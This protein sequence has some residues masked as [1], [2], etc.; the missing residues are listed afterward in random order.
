MIVSRLAAWRSVAVLAIVCLLAAACTGGSPSK[1]TGGGSPVAAHPSP[2]P[3]IVFILT[4]DLSMNLLPY[5][6]HVQALARTGVTFNNYFVVDSLCCP[7]RSAI[8]TGQYPHNNGVFRNTGADGGYHAYNRLGNEPKTFAIP[9]RTAGYRTGFMGKYLNGY[10]PTDRRAPGW[11]TWDGIGNGYPE[12]NYTINENGKQVRYGDSPKD[13]LNNV[14]GA[15]ASQFIQ[16]AR[17]A[18]KPFALEVGT[19]TPHK[20][21]IPAPHDV[22]TFPTLQV[23]RGPAFD[24]LPNN[25]PRWLRG[26]PPLSA[27]DIRAND[28]VF[29]LRVEAVQSVDRMIGQLQ[30]VLAKTQELRNTYFVFSSDNGFHIGEYRL[31]PGKTTAFDTDIKVPLIVAGPGI[32]AGQTVN[33]I[34]TSIDLSSTFTQMVGTKPN[35]AV[36]GVSLLPL[37]RGAKAPANWQQAVL[38]E[39]HGPVLNE[40]DPDVQQSRAGNPPS[41]E[42]VR[43]ATF[44][45]VEYQTGDREYY[46]LVHDPNELNNLAGLLPAL[47]QQQLHKLLAGLEACHGAPACQ[48]AAASAG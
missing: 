14:L 48:A 23:P 33:S 32:P 25:A 42:A 9:I 38:I 15:K 20:P 24:R 36:D 39:H 6:P 5:M 46:D 13:Y 43:T 30:Q 11:S 41:Y 8:F 7:S 27:S 26:F 29:R 10:A 3:N 31:M 18:G 1:T 17:N 16:N 37:M 35:D 28:Q 47:R 22:G 40:K 2:R 45:Y 4:D 12:Y 19:F 34:A 44:L 21:W